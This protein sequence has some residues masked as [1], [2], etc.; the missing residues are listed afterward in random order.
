MYGT[1]VSVV[2]RRIL[3]NFHYFV[4]SQQFNSANWKSKGPAKDAFDSGSCNLLNYDGS[5][6][7]FTI[8]LLQDCDPEGRDFRISFDTNLSYLETDRKKFDCKILF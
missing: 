8:I 5:Y 6:K 1:A 2:H 4:K 3:Y 7:V